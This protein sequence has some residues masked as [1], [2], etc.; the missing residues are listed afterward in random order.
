MREVLEG[1]LVPINWG[2]LAARHLLAHTYR[3]L[4]APAV[5]VMEPVA[6]VVPEAVAAAPIGTVEKAE[7]AATVEAAADALAATA[8]MEVM[9][10]TEELTVAEAEVLTAIMRLQG[11]EVPAELM[12]V[13]VVMP[14]QVIPLR[15]APVAQV[16]IHPQWISI[17]PV[18]ALVGPE[19]LHLRQAVAVQV[20]TAVE[21]AATVVMVAMLMATVEQAAAATVATVV[22]AMEA[23]AATVATAAQATAAVAV[24]AA[25]ALEVM[26][27]TAPK[28]GHRLP[29]GDLPL[30][31]VVVSL[32]LEVLPEIA[33]RL[34][35]LAFALSNTT[36][37]R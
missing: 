22:T 37:T 7:M 14:P 18:K 15:V 19:A 16:Q 26:E 24:A 9:A 28:V 30:V 33:R 6:T 3:Q 23:V 4:A 8:E 12:E 5:M 13:M 10:A 36:F 32:F 27:V 29:L 21:A 17:L 31:A 1:L 20:I 25:M 11:P 35:V 2:K 34:V